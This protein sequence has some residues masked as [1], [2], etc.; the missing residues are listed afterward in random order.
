MFYSPTVPPP[1]PSASNK[2]RNALEQLPFPFP[3]SPKQQ[4]SHQQS[5]RPNINQPPPPTSTFVVINKASTTP[6][7]PSTT[8]HYRFIAPRFFNYNKLQWLAARE[9]PVASPR[10]ARPA[11]MDPRSS[12][13]TLARLVFRL[14]HD[15]MGGRVVLFRFPALDR[16]RELLSHTPPV[17]S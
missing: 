17:A 8:D 5:R 13:A 14:V 6:T 9:N 11:S 7:S 4:S 10:E 15:F 1:S 3:Q 16:P 2:Q 12:R